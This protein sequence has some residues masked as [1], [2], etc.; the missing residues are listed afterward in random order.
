MATRRSPLSYSSSSSSGQGYEIFLNFS[1]IYTRNTFTN[2]LYNALDVA[3]IHTFM[4]DVQLRTGEE[5]GPDLLSAIQQ[6]RISVPIFSKNYVS[7]KWCLNEL[8]EIVECKKTMN[9][10]VLPIFYHVDPA[11]VRHYTGIYAEA[12][13]KHNKRVDQGIIDEWKNALT[14]AGGL[15]GWDLKNIDG[16]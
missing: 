1:S 8:V 10:H 2:H 7:S 12:L 4:D 14:E 13:H 6:S 15:K 5:I 16:G 11:E 9:Q 3:G